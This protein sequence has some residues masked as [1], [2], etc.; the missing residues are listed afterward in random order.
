MVKITSDIEIKSEDYPLR[1]YQKNHLCTWLYYSDQK[2]NVSIDVKMSATSCT[3][4][5]V[6]IHQ[7]TDQNATFTICGNT[8]IPPMRNL[9]RL[10]I[11]MKV[12][13]VVMTM[14]FRAYFNLSR[15]NAKTT[16]AK[17]T[18]IKTTLESTPIVSTKPPSGN[19]TLVKTSIIYRGSPLVIQ[20]K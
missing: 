12:D 17:T 20:F 3:T 2:F 15:H 18:V 9:N 14:A 1:I 4:S 19:S 11:I 5:K 16:V 13:D 6:E 10:L 7:G 8:L